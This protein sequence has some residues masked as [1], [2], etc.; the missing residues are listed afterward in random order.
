MGGFYGRAKWLKSKHHKRMRRP[1]N[2]GRKYIRCYHKK[3]HRIHSGDIYCPYCKIVVGYDTEDRP[4]KR[5]ERKVD[6]GYTFSK[7]NEETHGKAQE[8]TI[9]ERWNRW[10]PEEE[11][12]EAADPAD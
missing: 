6:G 3:A 11:E 7:K 9:V 12:G 10:F 4:E 1:R 2:A 5:P 8:E